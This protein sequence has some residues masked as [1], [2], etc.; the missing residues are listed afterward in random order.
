[1]WFCPANKECL[2]EI[3][4]SSGFRRLKSKTE[5]RPFPVLAK[6]SPALP[7]ASLSLF[8]LHWKLV[9]QSRAV[10]NTW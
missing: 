10:A 2:S 5:P 9:T 4:V 7:I 1:M 8:G 3:S 6:N